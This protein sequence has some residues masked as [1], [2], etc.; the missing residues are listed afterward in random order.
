MRKLAIVS[1]TAAVTAA[2]AGL[3]A[4]AVANSDPYVG[5]WFRGQGEIVI[6]KSDDGEYV[7]TVVKRIVMY[8]CW[9]EPGQVVVR[10]GVHP[11]LGYGVGAGDFGCGIHSALIQRVKRRTAVKLW[12]YAKE[13]PGRGGKVKGMRLGRHPWRVRGNRP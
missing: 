7:G 10:F 6:T 13:R 12:V 9:Y 4:A 8:D 11:D 1:I 5:H 3:P 2:A